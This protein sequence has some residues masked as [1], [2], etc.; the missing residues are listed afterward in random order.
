MA[1]FYP[2]VATMLKPS[3]SVF[4]NARFNLDRETDGWIAT[5]SQIPAIVTKGKTLVETHDKLRVAIGALRPDWAN[6]IISSS[7][8]LSD[9]A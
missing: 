2:D 4:L 3:G 8:M 1:L 6:A 5:V 7:V 9:V